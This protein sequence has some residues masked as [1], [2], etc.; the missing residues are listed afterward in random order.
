MENTNTKKLE[1]RIVE[2]G[3]RRFVFDPDITLEQ[4]ELLVEPLN[5]IFDA[6]PK[7]KSDDE[8]S[9]F[10]FMNTTRNVLKGGKLRK[11]LSLLLL[12]EG[13][14]FSVAQAREI[15]TFLGK[16]RASE[17]KA[18]EEVMDDFFVFMD[19]WFGISAISS[20]LEAKVNQESPEPKKKPTP[21]ARQ[22]FGMDSG[23]RSRK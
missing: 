14:E 3:G 4:E 6:L 23:S 22:K 8:L 2:V 9:M 7:P 20:M 10:D 21:T 1:T 15:E 16:L 12:P 11:V 18:L 13:K 17:R 19:N 5:E